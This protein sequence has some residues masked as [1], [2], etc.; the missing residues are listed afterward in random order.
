MNKYYTC[1]MTSLELLEQIIMLLCL[2]IFLILAFL[3]SYIGILV[4]LLIYIASFVIH[5]IQR[6]KRLI[7]NSPLYIDSQNKIYQ[8]V[9]SPYM[10]ML[11]WGGFGLIIFAILLSGHFPPYLFNR[12]MFDVESYTG[13][14]FLFSAINSIVPICNL[15]LKLTYKKVDV[16]KKHVL[17][18]VFDLSRATK[19]FEFSKNYNDYEELINIYKNEYKNKEEVPN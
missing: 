4:M 5:R 1:K 12:K 10:I 9:Y 7:L 14:T 11:I 8:I 3:E 15:I 13:F 2:P 6:K 17:Y 18:Y 19:E 16:N